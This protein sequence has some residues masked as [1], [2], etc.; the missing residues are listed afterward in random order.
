MRQISCFIALFFLSFQVLGQVVLFT[1]NFG[2]YPDDEVL[3]ENASGWYHSG[4]GD[5]T[6]NINPGFGALSSNCF[7]QLL[8]TGAASAHREMML[9]AGETYEFRAWLKTT[10]NRIYSTIRIEVDGVDVVTSGFVAANYQWEELVISYT[11]AVDELARFKVIKTQA[12]VLNVDK[13]RIVCTSCT[14]C[15]NN[16][17]YDFHDSKEGWISGGSSN[18]ALGNDGMVVNALGP[19]VKGISG[20]VSTNLNLNSDDF[21]KARI[22]FLTPYAAAGAGVGKLYLYDMAG[23]NTQFAT[24]DFPR[25]PANTTTYQT[26]E[27]DLTAPVAGIYS[28]NQEIARVGFRAPWGIA[29]GDV[30]L[31]QNIELFKVCECIADADADGICDDVDDCVGNY[32]EC[33]VC[34]GN[35]IPAGDCDCEGNQPD[36]VGVCG[37]DCTADINENGICDDVDPSLLY[38]GSGT[39]WD[40][41]EGKCVADVTCVE[42]LDADGTIGTTDLLIVLAAFGS[43]CP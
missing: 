17:V 32:D 14:D 5:F 28:G 36:V 26:V 29:D 24:Y 41:T 22:T 3:S 42:D 13:V 19:E 33:G 2:A 27:I 4:V 9:T 15:G 40:E 16:L 35:G 8:T 23:G 11:P 43:D 21:N 31:V 37:G 30:L 1:D 34:N 39:V 12:Q 25:D 18:L 38:C 6:N 10:N 20:N 7:G